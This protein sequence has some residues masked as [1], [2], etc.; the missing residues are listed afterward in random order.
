MLLTQSGSDAS[1]LQANWSHKA[2]RRYQLTDMK[3]LRHVN[4]QP[5]KLKELCDCGHGQGSWM[6]RF[7]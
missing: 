1:A 6:L 4:G 7:T 2:D 5:C 3:M